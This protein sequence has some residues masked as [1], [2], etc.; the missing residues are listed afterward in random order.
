VAAVTQLAQRSGQSGREVFAACGGNPFHVTEY[1]EAMSDRAPRAIEELT[2]QR[3]A[4]LGEE[5]RRTLE[6]ASIFP[7]QIDEEI[8]LVIAGAD[9]AGV[10]E[11]LAGGMLVARGIGIG[12]EALAFRHELA[13]RAINAAMSPLRRRELHAAALALLKT[14]GRGAA[15]IAHHAEQAGAWSDLVDYSVRAAQEAGALGAYREAM[16]HLGR[17]LDHGA[18]LPVEA[19]MRLLE[20]RAFAAYFCGAFAVATAALDEAIALQRSAGLISGLGEALRIA[21]HVH[22]NLGDA[23]LGERLA[24]EAVQVLSA[25]PDTAAYAMA[26]A[27]QSQFD[28]LADRNA[29]AIPAAEEARERAQRLS[30]FDIALQAQTYLATAIASTDLGAGLPMLRA[31]IALARE[32]GELDVLPRL[33]AN[34]TSVMASARQFDGF[35]QAAEDGLIACGARDQAPLE[36]WIRGNRA[37]VRI[38]MGRLEAAL[39]EAEDVV[40][41]PYPRAS[42]VLP[43]MLAL[44]RSRTRIGLPEGGLVQQAR[45]YPTVGRDL[46]WRIPVAVAG[47]EAQWLDGSIPG[48]GEEL[49]GVFDDLVSCWAQLWRLDDVVLWLTLLGRAP[50]LTDAVAEQLSP[51]CRAFIDRR[52]QAAA[53]LWEAKGCPYEQA[54]ALSEGDEAAQREALALF[55]ALGA[56]P[57]AR[58]LRRRLRAEGVRAVPSG[59]RAAR[60]ANPAGLTRRQSDVLQLLVEGLANADIAERLGLSAKTVEHHVSAVLAALEAPSRLAAAQIARDRGLYESAG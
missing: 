48:A 25:E 51:A 36:A 54:I 57:A 21:A 49:A 27:S 9:H 55:D 38:D 13:R 5:A 29:L 8:L 32:K 47:A 12:G 24:G 50:A 15:E 10:E 19:R 56:A 17:A 3:A 40:H 31:T 26:L 1:L 39:A 23:A 43:A 41:G 20:R 52:W 30:R 42:A 22:W 4:R 53:Q 6:C 14:R 2:V 37:N 33:Y 44:S 16:T 58:N 35:E 28:M 45:A 11:C 7:R 34:L 59:P 18:A 60:R 46:L